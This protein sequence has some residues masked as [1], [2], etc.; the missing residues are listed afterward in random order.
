MNM[1]EGIAM[2]F[3]VDFSALLSGFYSVD[4]GL[5]L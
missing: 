5:V 3:G 2:M 1:S 4:G